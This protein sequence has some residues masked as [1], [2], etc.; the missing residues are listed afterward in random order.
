MGDLDAAEP[1]LQGAEKALCG[2]SAAEAVLRNR[3]T[4]HIAAIRAYAVYIRG[5]LRRATELASEALSL[6][7]ASDL[8]ARG[9]ATALLGAVLKWSGDLAAA[10]R[11]SAEAV[12]ISREAGDPNVVVHAVCDMATVQILRG[13]L[14]QAA[15]TCRDALQIAGSYVGHGARPLPVT[16]HAYA[17]LSA[18]Q[19]EWNDLVAAYHNAREGIELC[20]LSG[21]A[22]VLTTGYR[23]LSGALRATG[24]RDGALGAIQEARR[25]ANGVSSSYG[26]RAA[27]WEARLRL[28]LGDVDAA[29]GWARQS[30]LRA[31]D[32]P[33]FQYALEYCTLARVLLAKRTPEEALGLLRRLLAMAETTGAMGYAVEILALQAVAW[34]AQGRED[35]ALTALERGLALAEPEGY[36]RMFADEGE[37]MGE[38]LRQA[39]ARG[40]APD[41]ASRLLAALGKAAPATSAPVQRTKEMQPS[42]LVEPLSGRELDVLKLLAQ[43]CADKKIAETLVIARETIHKHLRNIYGK[44]DVHNRTAAV[45]RARELGLL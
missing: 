32:E 35:Q 13:Q 25:I 34:H 36:V 5:D 41:Y 7:P 42:P 44:L 26:E 1:L 8:R 29:C 43:G 4:G 21:Q 31:D 6:I 20:K 45:A 10:G 19:L 11:A 28:S 15:A 23:S 16:G 17:L 14:H 3:I 39:A 38:L 40:T 22:D 9:F 27:A 33:S 2:V 12:A 18:V 24:D 30:K 37:P